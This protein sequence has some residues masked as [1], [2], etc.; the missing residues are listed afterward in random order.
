MS[1]QRFSVDPWKNQHGSYS[2]SVFKYS[3]G[4]RIC[5][6]GGAGYH[7]STVPSDS[8]AAPKQ[9]VPASGRLLD[10]ARRRPLASP[11]SAPRI[12]LDVWQTVLHGFS[13]AP[14]QPKQSSKRFCT[15]EPCRSRKSPGTRGRRG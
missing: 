13:R 3:T 8:T 9:G 12:S 6:G 1:V 4:T 10:K 14:K 15:G 7:R 11:S 5:Y 2:D